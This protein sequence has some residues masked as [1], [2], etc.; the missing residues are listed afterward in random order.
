MSL[1][2][3]FLTDTQTERE[4]RHF[5]VLSNIKEIFAFLKK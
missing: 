3:E 1:M 2:T 4:N 5:H